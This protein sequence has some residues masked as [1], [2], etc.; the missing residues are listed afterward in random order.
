MDQEHRLRQIADQY[1]EKAGFKPRIAFEGKTPETVYN[2]VRSGMGI[3][4]GTDRFEKLGIFAE[5]VV[6]F[7]LDEPLPARTYSVIY[8]KGRHLP[9]A[10]LDFIALIKEVFASLDDH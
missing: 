8:R 10:T 2:L 6:Y 4:F 3:T 1:F 5:D 9:Q 7:S